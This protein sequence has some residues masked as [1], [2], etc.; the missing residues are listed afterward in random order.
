MQL[1]VFRNVGQSEV[2][3]LLRGCNLHLPAIDLDRTA[4]G[5]FHTEKRARHIRTTRADQPG[6]TQY[7]SPV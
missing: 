3:R 5:G 2:D 4:G 6:H 1:A 7:L